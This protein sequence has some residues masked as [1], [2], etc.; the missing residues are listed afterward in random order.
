MLSILKNIPGMSR[1]GP[2]RVAECQ[3]PTKRKYFWG[4][5]SSCPEASAA[6]PLLPSQGTGLA[7]MVTDGF[8]RCSRQ[9]VLYMVQSMCNVGNW[10]R[11]KEDT[12]KDLHD[13]VFLKTALRGVLSLSEVS[14]LYFLTPFCLV[15]SGTLP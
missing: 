15:P 1:A 14:P 9:P 12:G 10:D 6:F 3:K 11:R 5:M 7:T 8:T 13:S 2:D 4:A